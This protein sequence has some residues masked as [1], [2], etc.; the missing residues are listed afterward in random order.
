MDYIKS[1]PFNE[2]P[3]VFGLH[4]N[5]NIS[6]AL[7]ETSALLETA[8]GLQPR[9]S[10]DGGKSWDSLLGELAEDILA[11]M[12]PPFDVERALLDFPVRYSESMNTVLTQELIR[13]N[14]LAKIITKT[15]AEVIK[16]IKGLVVMSSELEQMGNS[17][18]I[19]KVQNGIFHKQQCA[20]FE[21]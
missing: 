5:A 16:A 19:G 10:G 15:L 6:C 1:L 3:E 11:R 17:M 2:G 9:S 4:T 13:F 7:S 20:D 18:V 21:C 14:G 8:L 12:P